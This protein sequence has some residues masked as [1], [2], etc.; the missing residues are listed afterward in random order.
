MQAGPGTLSEQA[1]MERAS[2]DRPSYTAIFYF[3][4]RYKL[5]YGTILLLILISS[6][7]ESLSVAA[8]FPVFSS[9]L[10]NS[11]QD[12]GGILGFVEDLANLMP[13]SD[14]IVAASTLLIIPFFA[15]TLF[16]LAREG[17]TAYASAAVSSPAR[18]TTSRSAPCRRCRGRRRGGWWRWKRAL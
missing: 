18:T 17:L 7:L 11:Q 2:L 16:T 13:F 9:L 6:A 3:L 10:G 8:F 1:D 15:K 5:L 14:P 4:S 12:M